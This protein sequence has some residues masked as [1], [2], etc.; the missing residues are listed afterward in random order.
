MP[1]QILRNTVRRISKR[2]WSILRA[3]WSFAPLHGLQVPGARR[4]ACLGYRQ[5]PRPP[6]QG[7]FFSIPSHVFEYIE[8]EMQSASWSSKLAANIPEMLR[9][10]TFARPS[11][12]RTDSLPLQNNPSR[13]GG[14]PDSMRAMVAARLPLLTNLGLGQQM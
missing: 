13:R 12:R 1:E 14:T 6:F 10:H 4:P 9:T 11:I 7:L 8:V 3:K 5:G 2:E